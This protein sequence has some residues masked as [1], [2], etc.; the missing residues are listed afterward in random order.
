MTA[1]RATLIVVWLLAA[2][3]PAL[4]QLPPGT[5]V[6]VLPFENPQAHPRLHW[7]REGMAALVGD[8]L[9]ASGL[10]VVGRD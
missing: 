5:V 7:L 2:T 4:A 9:D 6:V 10:E 3:V 1:R 8:V